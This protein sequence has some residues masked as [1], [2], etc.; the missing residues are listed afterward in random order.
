MDD[1]TFFEIQNKLFKRAIAGD[2]SAREQMILDNMHVARQVAYS[3]MT[4]KSMTDEE[5]V[6]LDREYIEKQ[7]LAFDLKIIFMTVKSVITR[8]DINDGEE[9]DNKKSSK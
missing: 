4:G 7:S 6:K 8:A 2:D 1:S 3:L 9:K 5:K